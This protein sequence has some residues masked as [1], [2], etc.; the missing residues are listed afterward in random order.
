[1]IDDGKTMDSNQASTMQQHISQPHPH[2]AENDDYGQTAYPSA[3]CIPSWNEQRAL[4][5][6]NNAVMQ[7]ETT[8]ANYTYNNA[9][10]KTELCHSW[11]TL[12]HC[13]YTFKCQFAH[14]VQELRMLQRH[15][16]YK[17]KPCRYLCCLMPLDPI[18][19]SDGG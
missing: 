1:M 19:L 17:T 3:E 11:S 8:A 10:Y 5:L 7:Q 9:R 18:W 4:L 6:Q 13:P 14:G 16:N 12:G 15:P 2:G